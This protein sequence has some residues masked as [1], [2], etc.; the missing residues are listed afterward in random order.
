M[1]VRTCRKCKKLFNYLVGPTICPT[2]REKMEDE[3]KIVKDYIREHPHIDMR[4]VSEECNVD[5]GQ[6]RQW[7]R[8]ERLEFSSD[9]AVSLNCDRCGKAIKS[10]RFCPECKRDMSQT[11]G[12]SI[13]LGHGTVASSKPDKPSK[14][15][16]K[17]RFIDK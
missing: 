5:P 12:N 7:V 16:P 14:E 13:G 6:I 8:E 2:C 1:D 10:G 11:F 9:S 15:S 17:M 3:F 4:T